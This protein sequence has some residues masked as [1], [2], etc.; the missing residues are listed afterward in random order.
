MLNFKLS[1]FV[2]DG[3]YRTII[4]NIVHSEVVVSQ[5]GQRPGMISMEELIQHKSKP[6]A[7]GKP[8]KE[9]KF[10]GVIAEF[11]DAMNAQLSSLHTAMTGG[12]DPKNSDW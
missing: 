10:D 4:E 12:S 9:N 3:R 6:K 8:S 11:E 7:N 5:N 1:V 2:K